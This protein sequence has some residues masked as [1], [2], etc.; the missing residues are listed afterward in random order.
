[1]GQGD[2]G[3]RE[4]VGAAALFRGRR[5][6]AG[7]VLR[8]PTLTEP[9]GHPM[10]PF[11]AAHTGREPEHL[12][13]APALCCLCG[14][15]DADPIAVGTDFEYRTSPD[16]FLA[17]RCRRCRLVYLNPRP[18]D[19]EAERIYPDDYHAF[20]FRP[21]EFGLVYRIRR[22]LEARRLLRWCRG[23]PTDARILDVG[24]GDGFHLGLLKE[25]GKPGWELEG[26][27]ADMRAVAPARA[28]GLT[29]HLGSVEE[30]DLP[31]SAYHLIL[32]VMTVEHLADPL[33]T[34]RSV[35][36]LLVPG[37]R[38]VVVTDNARSPDFALFGGRHW[39]G[40]H[41]PRHTYLFDKG[42][43]AELGAAAG[44]AVERIATAV[45]PVN[46]VYSL[47]NWLDDWGAPRWVVNRLSLKATLPL[48]FFTLLDMPLAAVGQGAILHGTF[49]K[50][51]T[52]RT[53]TEPM[54]EKSLR[55]TPS[56]LYSLLHGK[57]PQPM[58]GRG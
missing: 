28:S 1:M 6:V 22:R 27:D 7:S 43:L 2:E 54:I 29:I 26:V 16:E 33:E 25:F 53:S 13:L 45:S 50:P 3:R 57:Y 19:D 48:G 23:L 31:A 5:L 4:A 36:R 35:A 9:D 52:G 32:M 41:F 15:E 10:P 42:T 8:F 55:E 30:I 14:V 38:L 37:G 49:R 56:F 12:R 17:V 39:G 24:C 58:T 34:I 46:W 18:A 40:F 47:R 44:L 51:A 20:Q 21:A 11:V